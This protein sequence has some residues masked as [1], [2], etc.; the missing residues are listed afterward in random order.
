MTWQWIDLAVLGILFLAAYTRST[1]G[2]G[3]AVIA[4]P[5]LALVIDIKTATP[6]VALCA[7]VIASTILIKTWKK[8]DFRSTL[9]LIL[10]S[11]AGIPI[12]LLVLKNSPERFLKLVLG[13][14]LLFYG[15]YRIFKPRWKAVHDR[16]T[17]SLLFGF[18]AGILGGAYN[19]NGPPI[20]IYG[21]LRQWSKENFRATLQGYFFPTGLFILLG[22]GAAGL[23]TP[24]VFR[25]FILGLPLVFLGIFLGE[26]SHKAIPGKRFY[27]LV[28]S[29]IILMGAGLIFRVIA[30]PV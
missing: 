11:F 25:L 28:D 21:S 29:A 15:L 19:T 20:V 9:R 23:W 5:L 8:V 27:R 26:K 17:L 30:F 4:M 7:T 3:D 12:G 10:S 14:L 2:F 22:H 16:G 24:S 18:F 6:L 1:L 13:I